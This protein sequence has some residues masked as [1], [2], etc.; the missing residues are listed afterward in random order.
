MVV[1]N[2]PSINCFALKEV[3]EESH[4][5][6]GVMDVFPKNYGAVCEAPIVVGDFQEQK[7]DDC[8]QD[9]PS[10]PICKMFTFGLH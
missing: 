1:S 2:L 4:K 5:I 10:C 6:D 3:M 7:V 9:L 8:P